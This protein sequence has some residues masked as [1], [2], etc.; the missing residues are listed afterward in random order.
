VVVMH[1]SLP[2]QIDEARKV[3]RTLAQGN[4]R[5][6]RSAF[7]IVCKALWPFKTAEELAALV[8]CAVRTAAYEVS[9]EREPSA[10]SLA[11]VF[12][13]IATRRTWPE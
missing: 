9:G 10:R 1:G 2:R 11:A 8:G 3:E 4:A 6:C 5:L 13:I 12:N 7:G